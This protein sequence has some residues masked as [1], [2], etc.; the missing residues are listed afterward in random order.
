MRQGQID[1]L[2]IFVEQFIKKKVG[3]DEK[4]IPYFSGWANDE[5]IGNR[6]SHAS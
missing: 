1:G 2:I 5:F 3:S 4:K 6:Q